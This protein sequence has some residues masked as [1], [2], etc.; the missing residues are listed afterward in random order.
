MRGHRSRILV[1]TLAL[2]SHGNAS[3]QSPSSCPEPAVHT[4]G[5]LQERLAALENGRSLA[6]RC[7]LALLRLL[8]GRT[9]EAAALLEGI[10]SAQP[11][12]VDAMAALA[13]V[14]TREERDAQVV[15]LLQRAAA[16]DPKHPA[17][18]VLWAEHVAQRRA[19]AEALPLF[20][21]VVADHPDNLGALV[22]TARVLYRLYR[23]TA[24]HALLDRALARDSLHAPAH[25]LKSELH[26]RALAEDA[27]ARSAN[28]ALALDSLF[29][30]AQLAVSR[31][32]R[33]QNDV[34]GAYARLVAVL[35][36][37]PTHLETHRTLGNGGAL[38]S[39]G[40]YPTLDDNAVPAGL[41]RRLDLADSLQLARAYDR[42]E[43]VYN[44]VLN[45]QPGLAAA[46][47]GVA[48]TYYYRA[49]YDSAYQRF[50]DIAH[51]HPGLGLA[52]YGVSESIKRIRLLR[53]PR[54]AEALARFRA[55]PRPDE[56]ERLRDVFADFDRLDEDLQK[57]VLLSVAPLSNYIP[58]LALSG[59][60]YHLLP[61]HHRLWN[62]RGTA[63]SRGR[64]TFDGRLWDD[65]K[66]QG[67]R[68]AVAGEEW[69]REVTLERFNVL[70]H[71]FMH[72]IHALL[73]PT[74]RAA[75]NAMYQSA[76]RERHTLDSYADSNPQE[77]IAQAY[78]AFISPLKDP[79]L[80]GTAGNT[81]DRLHELDPPAY[82]FM[83]E[84][85]AQP[86]Y[87]PHAVLAL[88]QQLGGRG[89]SN[90][91][92]VERE[93][94]WVLTRYGEG[95]DI[96]A[97]Q[98]GLARLRGDYTRAAELHTRVIALAPDQLSGH[99][100]LAEDHALGWHDHKRAADI[101]TQYLQRDTSSYDGHIALARHQLAAGELQSA[102]RTLDRTGTLRMKAANANVEE[103][104]LRAEHARL[105]GDNAGAQRAYRLV[106]D[107]LQPQNVRAR[108]E[109]ALLAL[110]V[111]Q[112]AQADAWLRP[113][114]DTARTAD[115][116]VREAEARLLALNG[117]AAQALDRLI[118]L[119][120]SEPGRLETITALIAVARSVRPAMVADLIADGRRILEQLTPVPT[121]FEQNRFVARAGL[122]TVRA[123]AEFEAEVGR[124]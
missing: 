87:R 5:A 61:F 118:E 88:Q 17:V 14:H 120:G 84:I 80:G 75:I 74:Q 50:L 65:V 45:T 70:S 8:T 122:L 39:F 123:R 40:R 13:R 51:D 113:V 102:Q 30:D 28:R 12:N 66:G 43:A 64:R 63:Q 104:L 82:A 62:W 41:A 71:E 59:G 95:A 94:A 106:V 107:S 124:K 15:E 29:A 98:A 89:A 19:P 26:L 35:A 97:L 101:I 47:L 53:D 60:S 23:D 56:P 85:N 99:A 25:L 52:H 20:E 67:G 69:T 72:Q 58:I 92:V 33:Q 21:K 42:A 38:A 121:V 11:R 105:T 4:V 36:F 16:I 6:Q 10:L 7:E 2:L 119:R 73:T 103:M 24:A 111:S 68:N 44:E 93:A 90:V 48:S 18:R 46:R 57:I 54:N 112:P 117:S 49:N 78:E 77:Y 1:C 76:R 116:L 86:T 9:D 114:R 83:E 3:A 100:D 37:D 27:R 32:L 31:I 79:R 55:L 81:R 110:R 115:P 109:L 91:E 34:E 108:A 22:G 96:V